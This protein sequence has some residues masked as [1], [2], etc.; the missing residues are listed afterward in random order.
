MNSSFYLSLACPL[1]DTEELGILVAIQNFPPCCLRHP[2]NRGV[3]SICLLCSPL[4]NFTLCEH[5]I[6]VD[7]PTVVSTCV[8]KYKSQVIV[9]YIC[10]FLLSPETFLVRLSL[11]QK[12]ISVVLREVG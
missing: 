4:L 1:T 10:L 3:S 6:L 11:S 12:S 7:Y 8:L 5:I 9:R 2:G